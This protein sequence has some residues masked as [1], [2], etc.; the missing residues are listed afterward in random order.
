MVMVFSVVHRRFSRNLQVR[1][2]NRYFLQVEP[3]QVV[4][5]IDEMEHATYRG[6]RQPGETTVYETS[7]FRKLHENL[8]LVRF[9]HEIP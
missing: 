8:K 7:D 5:S 1:F 2:R 3:V 9:G 4:P 6:R